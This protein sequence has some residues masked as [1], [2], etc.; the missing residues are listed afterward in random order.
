LQVTAYKLMGALTDAINADQTLDGNTED[1]RV[2]SMKP[3]FAYDEGA[4]NPKAYVIECELH[5]Y[6]FIDL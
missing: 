6:L 5:G 4:S 2:L 1:I 3:S